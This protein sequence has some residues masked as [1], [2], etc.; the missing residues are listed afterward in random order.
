ML[1]R[2]LAR[3]VLFLFYLFI[4]LFWRNCT[5]LCLYEPV[6]A[7]IQVD[8]TMATLNCNIS[9]ALRLFMLIS[10]MIHAMYQ[11]KSNRLS[12][13]CLKARQTIGL[14]I[15]VQKQKQNKILSWS[16]LAFFISVQTQFS[17]SL[18]SWATTGELLNRSGNSVIFTCLLAR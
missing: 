14:R 3:H 4:F 18:W 2:T 13:V 5:V 7:M 12:V 15:I 6:F 8:T 17:I 16:W 1:N 10:T 11:N 9:T